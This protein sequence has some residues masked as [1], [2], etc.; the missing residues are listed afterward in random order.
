MVDSIA[1]DV[2]IS[3]NSEVEDEL[4]TCGISLIK[5]MHTNARSPP[6]QMPVESGVPSALMQSF[7]TM[8]NASARSKLSTMVVAE[9]EVVP[10]PTV[11]GLHFVWD[12]SNVST[13][14]VV[15]E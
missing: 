1:E 4:A 11:N 12:S 5:S 8:D 14:H 2:V 15:S 10:T 6:S 3:W 13:V 9:A 7:N